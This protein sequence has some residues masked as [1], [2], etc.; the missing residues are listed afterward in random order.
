MG[1]ELPQGTTVGVCTI[2]RLR[3][4]RGL[5]DVYSATGPA[6]QA[7]RVSVFHVDPDGQPWLHFV[8][9]SQQVQTLSHP[10][11]A[12]IVET[13][14][15]SSGQ[16]FQ[17]VRLGP[18]EALSE[19]LRR[20]GALTTSE[21]LACAQQLGSALSALHSLD[22]LHRGLSPDRIFVSEADPTVKPRVRLLDL[23]VTRLLDDAVPGGVWD[24]PEYKAPEQLTGFSIDV[25]PASDEYALALV[26][27]QSLTSSRPFKA[28][29]A[30]ATILQVVRGGA[31]PLRV[32]RP[33]ISKALDVAVTRALAKERIGRFASI[34]EFLTALQGGEPIERAVDELVGPWLRGAAST[35][36]V[37]K[38]AAAQADSKPSFQVVALQMG[39]DAAVP[40]VV[41]DQATVPNTM[42]EVMRLAV[43][44][45]RVSFSDAGSA[46]PQPVSDGSKP[47]KVA[48][49]KPAAA[50]ETTDRNPLIE[51]IADAPSTPS[52]AAPGKSG[53]AVAT[54]QSASKPADAA[55]EATG[56][57]AVPSTAIATAAPTPV[58]ATAPT[59][60]SSLIGKIVLVVLGLMLGFLLRHLLG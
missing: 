53:P 29:S 38:Q 2:E 41:E 12:D 15:T 24:S 26:L 5:Y 50:A 14:V 49:V 52:A 33:D 3:E 58:A 43:P 25:G 9:E 37:I 56:P 21:A 4:R 7:C 39:G 42:E 17:S 10:C 1:R 22:L 44:I 8:A 30:A 48:Q 16:P 60:S 46:S 51:P 28:D 36:A 19:R 6:G 32:L 11:L 54:N 45:E 57:L 35:Q 23:G 20:S 27:Y 13:A 59:Q 18:G 31:E 40:M 55:A 47:V 34:A